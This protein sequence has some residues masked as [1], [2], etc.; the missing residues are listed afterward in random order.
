MHKPESIQKNET[1]KVHWDFEK[2]MDH[3]IQV[4]RPDQVEF[5]RKELI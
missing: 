5:R 2:Q 1:Y 4:K 3:P